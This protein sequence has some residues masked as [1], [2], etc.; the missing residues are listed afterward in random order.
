MD[1]PIKPT[2]SRKYNIETKG[3]SD[4]VLVLFEDVN[5]TPR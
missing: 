1:V 2:A 4:A 3:P 5:G